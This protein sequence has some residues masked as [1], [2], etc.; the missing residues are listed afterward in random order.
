M[1]KARKRMIVRPR[2]I[3]KLSR[4]QRRSKKT[5]TPKK[6]MRRT[7]TRFSGRILE[8]TLSLE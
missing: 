7:N 5:R 1:R 2:M 3:K 4:K 8:R 6:R